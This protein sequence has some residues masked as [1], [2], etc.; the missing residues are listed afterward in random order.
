M[1]F[2]LHD[3]T[4]GAKNAVSSIEHGASEALHTAAYA[5][6]E[7]TAAPLNITSKVVDGVTGKSVLPELHLV[8]EPQTV[9]DVKNAFRPELDAL[10][11][12]GHLGAEFGHSALY[13]GGQEP[14]NGL[15]QLFNKVTHTDAV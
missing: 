13:Y 15:G 1:G 14:I 10:G 11:Y 2:S 12:A 9:K 7:L 6:S 3:I 4:D 5:G 8:D